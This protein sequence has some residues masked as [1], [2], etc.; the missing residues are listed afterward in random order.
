MNGL[1]FNG[2]GPM[3]SGT[4]YN[5]TTG[6]SF[7]V[8]DSFFQDNQYLVKTTDGRMLDY[9]FIQHYVKSDK[10]IPKMTQ[11]KKQ[12]SLPAEVANLIAPQVDM[13]E[14]DLALISGK[15]LGNLGTISQPISA[16]VT[17]DNP[18]K[19]IIDKALSKRPIP[20]IISTIEWM[21]FPRKELDMLMDVMD[22]DRNEILEWYM[23]KL[24]LNA[25][26]ES[27]KCSLNEYFNLKFEPIKEEIDDVFGFSGYE[28]T[29]E[30]QDKEPKPKKPGRKKK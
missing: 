6:D 18:N 16:G 24:D 28:D 5:P 12:E 15:N 26:K 17:Y 11:P 9:N 2:E 1:T 10:P 13:L 20:I 30:A 29:Q 14:D 7:T 3:M 23:S 4:W 25:I 19:M 8:A 22:V 27:I 21:Q